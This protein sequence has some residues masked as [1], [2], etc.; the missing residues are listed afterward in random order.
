MTRKPEDTPFNVVFIGESGV[1]K[2][3][4]IQRITDI[5]ISEINNDAVTVT[6]ASTPYTAI[7]SANRYKIWD[8]PGLGGGN[9]GGVQD[10]KAEKKLKTLLS[11]LMRTEGVHL[12][13]FCMRKGRL[14]ALSERFYET[15]ALGVCGGRVPVP[16]VTVITNLDNQAERDAWWTR[17]SSAFRRHGMTFCGHA[18]VGFAPTDP[19]GADTLRS[20]IFQH[21]D[22]SPTTRPNLKLEEEE[23]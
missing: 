10:G 7:I 21:A 15:F 23:A 6:T 16:A 20:L 22:E 8:T 17:N 5:P 19:T 14:T 9:E 3:S 13:V 18:C 4:V 1:G 12:L 2:S 11:D